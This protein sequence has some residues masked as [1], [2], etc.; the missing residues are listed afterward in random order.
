MF[1][2]LGKSSSPPMHWVNTKHIVSITI[3]PQGTE[4][5]EFVTDSYDGVGPY[6]V[7]LAY[8]NSQTIWFTFDT[9]KEAQDFATKMIEDLHNISG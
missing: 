4:D 7:T 6:R 9:L 5:K 2:P 1:I 8:V 3:R